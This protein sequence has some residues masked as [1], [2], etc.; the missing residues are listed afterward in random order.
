MKLLLLAALVASTCTPATKPVPEPTPI[1]D[2]GAPFDAKGPTTGCPGAIENSKR[3]G[4]TFE[5]DDAGGWCST[6]TAAQVSCLAKA[7]NC[8]ATRRCAEMTK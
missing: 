5:A 1:A 4:C 7:A 6:L 3:L 2:S 8:L